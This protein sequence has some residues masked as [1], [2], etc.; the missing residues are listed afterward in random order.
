M[1]TSAL[2]VRSAV[3]QGLRGPGVTDG[4][5]W[6]RGGTVALKMWSRSSG[7]RRRN[8]QGMPRGF[9]SDSYGGVK[10]NNV[11]FLVCDHEVVHTEFPMLL[12]VDKWQEDGTMACCR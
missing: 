8:V 10:V 2:R 1:R 4:S 5:C 9:D 12:A 3:S 6:Y 11:T 7:G